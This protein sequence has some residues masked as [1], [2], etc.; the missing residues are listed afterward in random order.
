[1][2]STFLRLE[3]DRATGWVTDL[4]LQRNMS[5]YLQSAI[6]PF[7][8][9]QWALYWH[10]I[11][12]RRSHPLAESHLTA[13]LQET[14]YWTAQTIA[15]NQRQLNWIVD[16]FQVAI[17]TV[18]KLLKHF[19]PQYSE[20]LK[21]YAELVFENS[22]K[23]W[24]R[25][26]EQVAVCTD[27]ALLYRLSRKRLLTALETAGLSQLEIAQY[28]LVW[29]CFQELTS[30]D[31]SSINSLRCPTPPIWQAIAD[32]YNTDRLSQV[33]VTAPMGTPEQVEQWLLTCARLVRHALKPTIISANAP[34]L[35]QEAGSPIDTLAA[36]SPT[37]ID[38]LLQQEEDTLRSQQLMQLRTVLAKAFSDLSPPETDLLNN[39]Y[40]DQLTQV[41]IAKQLGIKQFEVSRRLQRIRRSLAKK[42]AQ[43]SQEN[44]HITPTPTVVDEMSHTFIEEWLREKIMSD[45]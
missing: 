31:H 7:T 18:P 45:Q 20:N 26:H 37:P 23:D 4:R 12:Q 14:C 8:D 33:G 24:L 15:R 30:V 3:S 11:W 17:S 27:W 35:G 5:A 25:V 43:W 32:A 42:V 44:L 10:Q 9:R 22:L 38:L 36:P 19:N 39:Y 28:T 2:F 6:Q 29:E 34:R 13:Y 40:R 41:E 21:K 16:L 1:M